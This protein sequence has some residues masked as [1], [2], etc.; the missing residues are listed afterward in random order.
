MVIINNV[1]KNINFGKTFIGYVKTMYNNIESTVLNNGNTGKYFNLQ[2]GVRQGCPLS[3][4]LFITA[5]ETLANKIRNNSN[6]KGINVD[7]KEIKISLLADD[8]TLILLDLNSVK[9]S[10][11]VLKSFSNC[12]GLKINVE[13]TQAKYIGPLLT[14]DHFPHGLSWI[15]T[16]ILTLGIVITDNDESNFRHNFQQKIITLKA[17]LNVWKQR[18]LSLKGKITILNNLALASITYMSSAVNPPNKA[19]KEINNLIQNF[20]WDGST[21]KISQRTLI[22]QID[23]G[24]LKLCHFETKVKALK[25]TW[26]KRLVSEKDS[27]WKI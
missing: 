27:T 26:I 4:Y 17:T 11:T 6:I 20:I 2:R 9:T 23:K 14:C 15:K 22:Q 7:N 8:I 16:P 1:W 13:K 19:I 3:A 21:S 10:L 25:L 12:A 5:L 24:G 18:K